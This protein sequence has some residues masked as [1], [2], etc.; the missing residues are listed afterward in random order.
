MFKLRLEAKAAE[1]AAAEDCAGKKMDSQLKPMVINGSGN[2]FDDGFSMLLKKEFLKYEKILEV[3]SI[4]EPTKIK[5]FRKL[6]K[7]D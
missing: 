3:S 5:D 7:I 1:D 2:G 6:K 4:C